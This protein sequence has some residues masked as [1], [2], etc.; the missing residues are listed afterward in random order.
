MSESEL[1][2]KV[3]WLEGALQAIANRLPET[4]EV[5]IA[6][7]ALKALRDGSFQEGRPDA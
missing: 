1:E 2:K 6:K 3:Q 5:R 4:D 7:E